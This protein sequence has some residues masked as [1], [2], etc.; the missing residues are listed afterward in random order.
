MVASLDG[1][2][3]SARAFTECAVAC[4]F[5]LRAKMDGS[6]DAAPISDARFVSGERERVFTH[7][8]EGMGDVQDL[9]DPRASTVY[10]FRICMHGPTVD[11]I[12][13]SIH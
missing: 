11:A 4:M 10:G 7:K 9:I 2:G 6:R 3:V 5:V 12:T 13:C 1:R 8:L